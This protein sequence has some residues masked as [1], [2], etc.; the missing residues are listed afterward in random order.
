MAVQFEILQAQ[1]MSLTKAE[2]TQLL[3]RLVA[4]LDVDVE[5]E[6]GWEQVAEARE[7]ELE[8]GAAKGVALE[9]A[10]AQLRVR[11]PG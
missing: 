10:M 7:L 8:S 9:D 1:V 11:F 2:R 4:S 6:E 3:E 5:A